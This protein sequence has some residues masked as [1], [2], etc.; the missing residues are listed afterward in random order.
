MA[1][2]VWTSN[3]LKYLNEIGEYIAQI[4]QNMLKGLLASPIIKL[5]F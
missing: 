1:E 2:I 3:A 5:R 4:P